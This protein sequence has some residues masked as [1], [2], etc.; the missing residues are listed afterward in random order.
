MALDH[1]NV[2]R[3]VERQKG[4]EEQLKHQS[5]SVKVHWEENDKQYPSTEKRE[6]WLPVSQAIFQST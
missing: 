1:V 2:E 5:T 4:K 3:R 6:K